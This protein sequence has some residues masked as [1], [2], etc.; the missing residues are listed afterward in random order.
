MAFLGMRY[1][2]NGGDAIRPIR[3]QNQR[4]GVSGDPAERVLPDPRRYYGSHPDC[5]SQKGGD[6]SHTAKLAQEYLRENS[7]FLGVGEWAATPPDLNS[8]GYFA[9]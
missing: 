3:R 2:G 8:L 5:I 7:S 1:V 9:W 4:G 6:S